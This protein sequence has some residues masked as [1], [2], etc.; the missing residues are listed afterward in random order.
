[1]RVLCPYQPSSAP[2]LLA[3]TWEM[4][5][6]ERRGSAWKI[7][8]VTPRVVSIA[9]MCRLRSN[10]EGSEKRDSGRM[11]GYTTRGALFAIVENGTRNCSLAGSTGTLLL[12][13][14]TS[15]KV[16]SHLQ[17][18]WPSEAP[19]VRTRRFSAV[20]VFIFPQFAHSPRAGFMKKS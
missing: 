4:R 12:R 10:V 2:C 20:R 7:A 17:H 18:V 1:V 19:G 8:K 5:F 11:V 6:H 3:A 14:V 9:D 13:S 16:S 15:H